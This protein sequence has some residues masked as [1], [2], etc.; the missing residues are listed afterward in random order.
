MNMWEWLT[1]RMRMQRFMLE[2]FRRNEGCN[3][4]LQGG[5]QAAVDVVNKTSQPEATKV[6]KPVSNT[7]KV[8]SS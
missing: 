1:R 5:L 6:E 2:A 7:R 4:S 3:W 8:A